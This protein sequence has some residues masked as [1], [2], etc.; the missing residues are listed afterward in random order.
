MAAQNCG[1][2]KLAKG[3]FRAVMFSL[4]FIYGLV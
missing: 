4:L 2:E 3:G 1:G